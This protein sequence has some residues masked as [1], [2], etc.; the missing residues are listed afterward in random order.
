MKHFT[1]GPN[2]I[3]FSI[4]RDLPYFQPLSN[5]YG[6]KLKSFDQNSEKIVL[7]RDVSTSPNTYQHFLLTG[8]TSMEDLE[9][10][11]VKMLPYGMWYY[12]IYP[13]TGGTLASVDLTNELTSGIIHSKE[14]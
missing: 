5:Y 3:Y 1:L 13:S 12:S 7:L 2:E 8:S 14:A 11:V 6:M 10:S 4:L 9:G